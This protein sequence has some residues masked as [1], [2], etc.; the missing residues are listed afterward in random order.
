MKALFCIAVLVFLTAC[1]GDGPL[2]D[3][4]FQDEYTLSDFTLA[5]SYDYFEVRRT[6]PMD[7]NIAP[8]VIV[9]YDNTDSLT[10]TQLALLSEANAETGYSGGCLPGYCIF[11]AVALLDDYVLTIESMDDLLVFFN[12]VDTPA[13]LQFY[14]A[15]NHY[16]ALYFEANDSGYEVVAAWD[17]ACGKRGE[18]LLQVD[19]D[20]TITKIRNIKTETYNG[21]A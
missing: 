13:E 9:Q 8:E 14:L 6:F 10:D 2:P 7:S 4:P 3:T 21:C 5:D 12:N 19:T 18:D 20:G 15:A 16:E 1:N 11:Y 17:N